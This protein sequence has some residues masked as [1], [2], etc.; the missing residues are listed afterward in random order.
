MPTAALAGILIVTGWRLVSVQHA[1]GL[2]RRHGALPAAVW[3]ATLIVVVAVDLLT[4]VL[5]GLALAGIEI[6]PHLKRRYLVVRRHET[7][8]GGLD[9]RLAGAATFLQLPQLEKELAAVPEGATVT[10]RTS[11]LSYIDH[12]TSEMIADWAERRTGGTRMPVDRSAPSHER[13]LANAL[14]A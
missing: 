14:P 9:M 13:R 11:H 10:L 5:V 2:F 4:G 7:K 1:R 8:D 6:V 12:T 3:A